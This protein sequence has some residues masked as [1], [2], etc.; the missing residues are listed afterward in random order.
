MLSVVFFAP[1]F[2]HVVNHSKP[3]GCWVESHCRL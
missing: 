1:P 2:V 3:R